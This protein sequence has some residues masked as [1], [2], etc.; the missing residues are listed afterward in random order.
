MRPCQRWAARGAVT[1]TR[2]RTIGSCIVLLLLAGGAAGPVGARETQ[3]RFNVTVRLH[4]S[5]H[6]ATVA[7]SA[8]S[9]SAASGKTSVNELNVGVTAPAG[10]FVRFRIVDPAVE[11]VD[12]HGPGRT[13]RFSSGAR[14]VFVP[15][16]EAG[17]TIL[18]SVKV[19]PGLEPATAAPVR[20]ILLP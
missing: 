18:Y 13:I 1:S 5:G 14:D 7:K 4:S 12:V 20:A 3:G 19:R 8:A 11:E 6:A 9:P 17:R 16:T 10:C 15:T 2:R